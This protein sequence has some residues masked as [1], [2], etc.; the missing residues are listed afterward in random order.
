MAKSG[1]SLSFFYL[2]IKYE[3]T[4]MAIRSLGAPYF[5]FGIRFDWLIHEWWCIDR[6]I[7]QTL[8][9]PVQ[10]HTSPLVKSDIHSIT[11]QS[12]I[13]SGWYSRWYSETNQSTGFQLW[14]Q[15]WRQ[16]WG[17]FFLKGRF[18]LKNRTYCPLFNHDSTSFKKMWLLI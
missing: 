9:V 2:K 13:L 17:R 12:T 16:F 5:E 8:L 18:S 10:V 6:S 4:W 7:D 3:N 11:T 15:Y 14:R 1:T